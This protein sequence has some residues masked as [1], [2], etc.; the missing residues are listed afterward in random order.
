MPCR[1][2]LS[3]LAVTLLALAGCA[4]P[5][6][7]AP[8]EERGAAKAPPAAAKAPLPAKGGTAPPGAD[9]RPQVYVVKKGDTLYSIA[10]EHGMDYKELAAINGIDNPGAL[11][12][13]RELRLS[14]PAGAVVTAPAL[15][16][17]TVEGRPLGDSLTVKTE[18]KG[19]KLPYSPEALAQ[20][21]K[22]PPRQV[23]LAPSGV[24]TQTPADGKP[25]P[26][27]APDFEG[28]GEVN[29]AWPV[30]GKVI[31]Q[32]TEQSKGVDISGKP[33]QPVH[34]SAPGRVLYSGD[35]IRGYGNL[36]II[37]HNKAYVSVYAHNR[38]L[39]VKE[40][41]AIGQGQR[42]AE[43]GNADT[44]QVKLHFEI[45]RFGKPVDPLR[46][47]PGSEGS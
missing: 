1:P 22:A 32:F 6:Y 12:M 5:R 17:S 27:A 25:A 30:A 21:Q 37:K 46:Y 40:G 28:E 31:T 11:A 7:G 15:I 47:L 2:I 3:V 14:R 8:V 16:P 29:W 45:R 26:P 34:A 24:Q 33:G 44:S 38:Q 42:I 13:G 18:P 39:L 36:I 23:A 43:M 4:G 10:L 41:Q 19:V 9:G 20:L 35:G